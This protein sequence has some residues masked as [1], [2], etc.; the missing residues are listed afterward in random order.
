MMNWIVVSFVVSVAASAAQPAWDGSQES[1][2][3]SAQQYLSISGFSRIGL[4]HQLSSD[5]GDGYDVIDATAAAD[6]LPVDWNEQ[7]TRSAKQCLSISGYSCKG[8]VHHPHRALETD[9]PQ[10]RRLMERSRPELVGSA[11]V[12]KMCQGTKQKRG[13]RVVK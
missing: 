11:T 2:A 4:I 5:S 10:A 9:T 7:A 1:A 3:R 8:L 12:L 13:R 6:S